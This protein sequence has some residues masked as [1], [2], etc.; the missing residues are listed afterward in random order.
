[1][2]TPA[3]LEAIAE[4]AIIVIGPGSLYTSILPNLLV[5]GIADAL[6]AANAPRIYVCNVATQPGE[7]GEYDAAD[8]ILAIEQHCGA[9]LFDYALINDRHPS[10][11]RGI[12]EYVLPAPA[13]H[14]VASRYRLH[15][16]DPGRYRTPL[17]SR[18]P[19]TRTSHPRAM[20]AT[21][22]Y[23]RKRAHSAQRSPL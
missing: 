4:A 7:T 20:C 5:G 11:N 1:M 23:R 15:Y 6:R 9:G 10:A 22:R 2:P 14:E 3:C 17:A 13:H 8:H 16:T 19:Q 21:R 12:T 18:S